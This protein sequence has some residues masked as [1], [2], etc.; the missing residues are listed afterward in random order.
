MNT[1]NNTTAPKLA[2]HHLER[3]E[4]LRRD[5]LAALLRVSTRTLHRMVVA[6]LVPPPL[7]LSSRTVRFNRIDCLQALQQ[8]AATYT[9]Q[10]T[11]NTEG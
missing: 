10:T 1:A 4:Y 3:L 11:T 7:K 9:G 6:G 8:A 5:E 2:H